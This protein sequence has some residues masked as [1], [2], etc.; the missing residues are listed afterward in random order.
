[1]NRHRPYDHRVR[2][3]ETL[4]GALVPGSTH[5]SAEQDS[6]AV[7][8]AG[9]MDNFKERKR[10]TIAVSSLTK[11]VDFK[12]MY[13]K[14]HQTGKGA[15]GIDQTKADTVAQNVM[16]IVSDDNASGNLSP[17]TR[18]SRLSYDAQ[19]LPLQ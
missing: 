19:I 10:Q 6:A 14:I 1:L 2:L 5:E 13:N 16:A 11:V 12:R 17:T 4:D 8:H 9:V 3:E 18:A 7:R 15:P